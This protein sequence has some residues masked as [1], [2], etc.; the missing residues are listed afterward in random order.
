MSQHPTSVNRGGP[1][2]AHEVDRFDLDTVL[3]DRNPRLRLV[4]GGEVR[5]QGRASDCRALLDECERLLA[6]VDR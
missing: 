6:E 3:V 1:T 5:Y 4:V 2:G